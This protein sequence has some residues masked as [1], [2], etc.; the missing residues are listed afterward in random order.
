MQ[1][2]DSRDSESFGRSHVKGAINIPLSPYFHTWVELLIDLNNPIT[3]VIDNKESMAEINFQL[4]Q[5][6]FEQALI[7]IMWDNSITQEKESSPSVSVEEV[8]TNL[9]HL[10]IIDVRS[11]GEWEED[12]LPTA[13]HVPITELV[14]RLDQ[15][16]KNQPLR[17]ICASGFRSAIAASVLQAAGF[18]RVA[19]IRGGMKAWRKNL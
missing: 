11:E 12:H 4:K 8:A 3:V 17:T 1:W 10:T 6:G 5:S 2:L 14:E 7:Y 13:M 18:D 19:N 15:I 16:P 9:N